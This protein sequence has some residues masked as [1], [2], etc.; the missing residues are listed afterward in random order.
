M[1]TFEF[2]SNLWFFLLALV[3]GIYMA[4]EMF[5]SGVG[6]LSIKFIKDLNKYRFINR[7]VG[8]HWDGIQVWLILAVG[9]TF[10]A[11]PNAFA[12]ILTNLYI[13]IFLLL[14][15]IIVRGIAIELIDKSDNEKFRN[16]LRYAWFISSILLIVVLAIYS[17]NLFI[18]L[19][20]NEKGSMND[21]FA[22]FLV[23][24][25]MIPIFT[26]VAFV[27]YS[28]SLGLL[29]LKLNCAKQI[30]EK[31]D[32]AIKVLPLFSALFL[33]LVI[34]GL[35]Q[36]IGIFNRGYFV[37]FPLLWLL[38]L[39]TVLLA[40]LGGLL[41]MFKKFGL[42]FISLALGMV[43]FMITGYLSLMPYFVYST[44]NPSYSLSIAKASANVS[45]LQVMLISTIIFL[46]IVIGYQAYKYIKFW[47]K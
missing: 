43:L 12:S 41:A 19:P 7:S 2:L 17:A 16:A 29:W 15:I 14:Y 35:N 45:T 42:S 5:V 4:Q 44:V 3:W 32:K 23:I 20:I 6:M 10:A 36:K 47:A 18:G 46:P 38:P 9:G 40:T 34:V 1:F 30:G 31:F 37:E 22:S 24:F 8:T 13:P 21:S 28:L 39:A 27:L 11:F 25:K 33:I 26:A